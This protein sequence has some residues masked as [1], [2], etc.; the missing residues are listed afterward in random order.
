MDFE[1]DYVAC[2]LIILM[3]HTMDEQ[4]EEELEAEPE[5]TM[6]EE[7]KGTE[8]KDRTLSHRSDRAIRDIR[9]V[10]DRVFDERTWLEPLEFMR[11]PRLLSRFDRVFFPRIDI[12]ETDTEV[13]VVADVPGIDPDNLDIEVHGDRMLIRGQTER[14]RKDTEEPYSYERRFG[15]FRREF[16]LPSRI[17]EDQV[18]AVCKNGMLTVTMQKEEKETHKKISIEKG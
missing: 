13:K 11:A 5:M 14:E 17:N 6:E 1:S 7:G 18:H 12:S 8:R 2:L 4:E 10:F 9:D 15:A 16:T 3:L